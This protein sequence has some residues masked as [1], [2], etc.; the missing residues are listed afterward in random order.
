MS[1]GVV[2]SGHQLSEFCDT[3]KYF[4]VFEKVLAIIEDIEVDFHVFPNSLAVF[5][6]LTKIRSWH[7]YQQH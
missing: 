4:T 1:I 3:Y 5:T 2:F 6:N 7:T